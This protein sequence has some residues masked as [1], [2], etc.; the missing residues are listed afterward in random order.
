METTS[1]ISKNQS[2]KGRRTRSLRVIGSLIRARILLGN[3]QRDPER[4][5]IVTGAQSRA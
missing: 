5:S 2:L 3:L 4:Q 1:P